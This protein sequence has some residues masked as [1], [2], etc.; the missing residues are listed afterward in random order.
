MQD[1]GTIQIGI[2]YPQKEIDDFKVKALT[3]YV[4]EFSTG[5]E[6]RSRE[7]D[8]I[9]IDYKQ[10]G[11]LLSENPEEMRNIFD[12]VLAGRH[13]SAKK[14]AKAIGLTEEKFQIKGGGVYWLIVAAVVIAI[15]LYPSEAK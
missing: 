2:N 9:R 3:E 8:K 6:I 12:D 1:F 14:K 4:I 15:L 10:L 13:D 5:E 7:L 11:N